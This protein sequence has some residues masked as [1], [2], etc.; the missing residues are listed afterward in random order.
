[1]HAIVTG[2]YGQNVREPI[3]QEHTWEN[4][5]EIYRETCPEWHDGTLVSIHRT[6]GGAAYNAPGVFTCEDRE[7]NKTV[8][9]LEA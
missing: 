9:I 8:V 1:M 2:Y 6:D 4:V 5:Q 3:D 7:G